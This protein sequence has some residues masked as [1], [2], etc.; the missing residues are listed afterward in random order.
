MFVVSTSIAQSPS[1]KLLEVAGKRAH[2]HIFEV[3]QINQGYLLLGT[4]KGILRYDGER[5]IEYAIPDSL[6]KINVSHLSVEGDMIYAGF[7]NGVFLYFP[8]NNYDKQTIYQVGTSEITSSQVAQDGSIWIGTN[9][10]GLFRIKDNSLKG[11]TTNDGLID[12]YVHCLEIMQDKL[13]VGTDLGLA[14]CDI[15]RS[16]IRFDNRNMDTG[17]S[18]NLILSFC[19]KDEDNLILGMQNGSLSHYQMSTNQISTFSSIN[20]LG[21]SGI[22]HLHVLQNDIM[23]ITSGD[24]AILM[25]WNNHSRL[26]QFDLKSENKSIRINDCLVDQEGNLIIADG[27]NIL[28]LADFR[29]QFIV[30][31]D[32]QPFYDS[33]CLFYNSTGDILFAND[34]GIFLHKTEFTKDQFIVPILSAKPGDAAI[35][36]L[37]EGSDGRIWFGTFGDGLGVVDLKTGNV[38]RFNERDG[39]LNNNVLSIT[40]H[41]GKIW[42]A[43]LGGAGSIEEA[44]G[45]Y[46][47]QS[48][49]RNSQLA[50]SY[51]YSVYTSSKGD[52]WFGTDGNGAAK[53]ESGEF[54]FLKNRYDRLGKSIVSIA[55][56]LAGNLWFYSSDMGLQWIDTSGLHDFPLTVDSEN[57]EVYAIHGDPLGNIVALSSLGIAILNSKSSHISFF[58][59]ERNVSSN[60]VNVITRDNTGQ[61][62]IGTVEAMVK[63]MEIA[64][65]AIE[66]PH[67]LLEQI[68]VV[69][70]P[71]DT[72]KHTY[73]YD[74]NHFTFDISAI[75]F[76][77]P[78]LINFECKLE[79]FD[80]DWVKTRDRTVVYPSL[81]PGNYRFLV[82][83]S[84]NE[85]W[86]E[87]EVV[88]WSFIINKPFWETWWFISGLILLISV[89]ISAIMRIRLNYIRRKESITRQK[90]Q[91]QFETLRNQVNPHFLFN[92]FNT[93]ISTIEQDPEEA[94][95]YVERLSDY[96]RVV[97]EQRDKD[98]ITLKEELELVENYLFLQ[99]KRFGKNLVYN[100]QIKDPS[101]KSLVPPMTIQ[102]LIENAIKHNIISKQRPFLIEI[103]EENGHLLIRNNLQPKL[104]KEPSTGIGLENIKNRYRILFD[105][106]IIIRETAEMFIVELPI[107]SITV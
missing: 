92:S 87:A 2:L 80:L 55:E 84:A 70:I 50:S 6:K 46:R 57:L 105:C 49:D 30:E 5:Y 26:Q 85:D 42:M 33:H 79:G 39:L 8:W 22:E 73:A 17:L 40:R 76:Q 71:T 100:I 47:F 54:V 34:N 7:E 28:T 43:T 58:L 78:E 107:K 25:N 3:H 52:L 13:M 103:V 93:L 37:C 19:L 38:L 31:H 96:F 94:V 15:L 11:Y 89:S 44:D 98:V 64:E 59:P 23:A 86:T 18:D 97:L 102:I 41:E 14:L 10:Q 56:D 82:R 29:I 72:S 36:S 1:F 45:T 99:Q 95:N 65:A 51:V 12:N 77:H 27:S 106:S 75:W 24:G 68:S 32:G 90:V 62:W 60:Y 20:S 16:D 88:S 61:L 91:S 74:Q 67:T 66:R 48:Y 104:L 69:L 53:Y 101:L 4:N 21:L 63:F 35:I 81:P 9:G 83:S